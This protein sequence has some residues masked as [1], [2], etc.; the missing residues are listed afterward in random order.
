MVVKGLDTDSLFKNWVE[1]A[2]LKTLEK[3]FKKKKVDFKRDHVS[4][5]ETGK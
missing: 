2:D 5:G 3:F 1:K 4:V